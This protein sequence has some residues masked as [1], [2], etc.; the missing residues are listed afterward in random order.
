MKKI[1]L[2]LLISICFF[3]LMGVEAHAF[4]TEAEKTYFI[5]QL[6]T[7]NQ[8]IQTYRQN[9]RYGTLFY[10]Q[11]QQQA[12]LKYK[13]LIRFSKNLFSS[14]DP[15][16]RQ[17]ES[18]SAF[19]EEFP[20]NT[21]SGNRDYYYKNLPNNATNLKYF[22]THINQFY[23]NYI[24]P[25]AT[26]EVLTP[27]DMQDLKLFYGIILKIQGT[28]GFNFCI[29]HRG[30]T[31]MDPPI[32]KMPPFQSPLF[33]KLLMQ[34][35]EF[36]LA[37]DEGIFLD[38]PREDL[39]NFVS[40]KQGC[41][42]IEGLREGP[43]DMVRNLKRT[44]RQAQPSPEPLSPG[45]L[46]SVPEE[47]CLSVSQ[48]G[49][50]IQNVENLARSTATSLGVDWMLSAI[51]SEFPNKSV[52]E[53]ETECG[54]GIFNCTPGYTYRGSAK[55]NN[56]RRQICQHPWQE[57]VDLYNSLRPRSESEGQVRRRGNRPYAN[58]DQAAEAARAAD[59]AER[60]FL[61]AVSR[62]ASHGARR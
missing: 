60:D 14:D 21:F 35:T 50:N 38:P 10:N 34:D 45:Q 6:E 28:P 52:G 59:A 43:L 48:E 53:A 40:S 8:E 26:K 37:I 39:D 51:H 30:A 42:S 4:L 58:V 56:V 19:R 25:M 41:D 31:P 62:A 33:K 20:E 1:Q 3:L 9:N 5:S 36:L 46:T 17:F 27:N 55:C 44:Q 61:H 13:D 7:L 22:Y 32:L 12:L 23:Q 2:L 54:E 49:S 15:F 57:V 18:L 29:D 24:E 16:I 11:S 47:T